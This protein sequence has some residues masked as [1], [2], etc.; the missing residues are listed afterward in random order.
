MILLG[1]GLYLLAARCQAQDLFAVPS[2]QRFAQHLYHV[3]DYKL[4]AEEYT[5]LLFFNP[6]DDSVFLRLTRIYRLLGRPDSGISLHQT[7]R[8]TSSQSSFQLE[9]DYLACLMFSRKRSD[10]EMALQAGLFVDQITAA[11]MMVEFDLLERHWAPAAARANDHLEAEWSPRYLHLA[12]RAHSIK[13]KSPLMAG[14]LSSIV[15]GSGK[16][17]TRNA[18]DAISSFAFVAGL[19]FQSYRGFRKRGT[20]SISGWLF[21]SMGLGFYLGSIHGSVKSARL[22]NDKKTLHLYEEIDR[23]IGADY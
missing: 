1:I 22:Y 4:A 21:G 8:S 3:G 20:E 15:P 16:V 5:R 14:I 17:Y 18:K 19:A 9:R 2:S 11:K 12:Q 6:T 7:F 10:F 13:L 23:T